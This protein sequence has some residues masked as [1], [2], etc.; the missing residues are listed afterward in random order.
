MSGYHLPV[1]KVAPTQSRSPLEVR[2][3]DHTPVAPRQLAKGQVQH[4]RMC[5]MFG[6]MQEMQKQ[7]L[8]L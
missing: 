1:I 2:L 6:Q 7:L 8:L 3:H 5:N 4:S